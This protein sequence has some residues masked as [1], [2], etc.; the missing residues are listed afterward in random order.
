MN[1]R[2]AQCQS[3]PAWKGCI[4]QTIWSFL[5][6]GPWPHHLDYVTTAQEFELGQ[7]TG[8]KHVTQL[9]FLWK[10][11]SIYIQGEKK[12]IYIYIFEGWEKIQLGASLSLDKPAHPHIPRLECTL[13][14][15]QRPSLRTHIV[16]HFNGIHI[17]TVVYLQWGFEGL[18]PTCLLPKPHLDKLNLIVSM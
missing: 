5:R 12:Y 9:K 7:S 16:M 6:P 17:D 4:A 2:Q 10:M 14:F 15:K 1:S 11:V 3:S 13:L 18:S 8:T